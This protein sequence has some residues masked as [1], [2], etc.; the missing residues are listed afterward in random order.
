MVVAMPVSGMVR[1][2]PP[3]LRGIDYVVSISRAP[4]FSF[5]SS[6][7][8]DPSFLL[9]LEKTQTRK[10]YFT[11]IDVLDHSDLPNDSSFL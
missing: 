8:I 1:S 9:I 6:D 2:L 10:L 4:T 7:K 5:L 11:R 3:M